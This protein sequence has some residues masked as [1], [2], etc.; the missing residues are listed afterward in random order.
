MHVTECTNGRSIVVT[1][2][3]GML[4]VTAIDLDK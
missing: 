2:D 3:E 4:I 1:F